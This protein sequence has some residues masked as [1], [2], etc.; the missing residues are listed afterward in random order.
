[1]DPGEMHNIYKEP[2]AQPV[3]AKLKEELARVKKEAGDTNNLYLDPK[4]WPKSTA[5]VL[6]P[7]KRRG[8]PRNE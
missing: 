4:T 2:A 6:A 5:D 8:A 3:V 7:S 1:M